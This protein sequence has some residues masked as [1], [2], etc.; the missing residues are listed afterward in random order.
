VGEFVSSYCSDGCVCV[1]CVQ[2]SELLLPRI[3]EIR[4]YCASATTALR[5]SRRKDRRSN[6][7]RF[8]LEL[9][10]MLRRWCYLPSSYCCSWQTCINVQDVPITKQCL[11]KKIIIS[12]T[13]A[14]HSLTKFSLAIN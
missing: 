7:E 10:S 11:R 1:S 14:D 2:A 4:T 6:M 5:V 12:V 9:T 8:T 3:V 13:V